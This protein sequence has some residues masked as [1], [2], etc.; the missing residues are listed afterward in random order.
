VFPEETPFDWDTEPLLRALAAAG[1]TGKNFA[2]ADTE[3]TTLTAKEKTESLGLV[4]R[5]F[6]NAESVSESE[7]RTLLGEA[8]EPLLAAGVLTRDEA[9][10]RS[11]I[12]IDPD[13]DGW[14]ASDHPARLSEKP[15]DF[16]MGIGRSTRLLVALAPAE[17]GLRALDLCTGGGWVALRLAAAGCEVTATDLNHRALTFARLNARLAGQDSIGFLQGDQL[18]PVGDSQFDLITANPPFV[19]SPESS[20]TFRDSGQVGSSFCENLARKLPAH[21]MP[22]GIAVIL[23]N[24]FDDGHDENAAAPLDWLSGSGCGRWLF[25]TL[26]QQPEEYARQW[27]KDTSGGVEPASA[28]M[29]RWLSHF[30]RIGAA[31]LHS[32]FLIV[33]RTSGPGWSRSDVRRAE[34]ILTSAGG[35]IR[36]VVEGE[37]WLARR[38]PTPDELVESVFRV[39]DGLRAESVSTLNEDWEATAI[40]LLSPGRLAY[41]GPVDAHL[42]R[43]LAH[44]R[45]GRSPAALIA[46]L[47]QGPNLPPPEELRKHTATLVRELVRHGL[48]LPPS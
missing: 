6:A 19:I 1:Y 29:D 14:F 15:A 26:T 33:H 41:D 37:S 24:W 28:D 44:C 40:R 13:G 5:L 17:R 9:R 22:D 43:L 30:Q 36:R 8:F 25:R 34:K 27:L 18:D 38:Q 45:D 46:E 11:S 20:L 3:Q 31:R 16:T 7:A 12:R 10:I 47:T 2:P 21:L 23:L 48:L 32:G 42:L 35:D 4:L 39:P